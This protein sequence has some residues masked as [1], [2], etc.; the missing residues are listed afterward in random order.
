MMNGRAVYSG[1]PL[2]VFHR[3]RELYLES[4]GERLARQSRNEKYVPIG[5]KGT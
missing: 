5:G 2:D 4:E 3:Y 1:E